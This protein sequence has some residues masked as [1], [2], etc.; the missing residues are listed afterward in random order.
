METADA[1]YPWMDDWR[2]NKHVGFLLLSDKFKPAQLEKKFPVFLEKFIEKSTSSPKRFYLLPLLD[3]HLNSKYIASNLTKSSPGEL[4]STISLAITFLLIV[5]LNFVNLSTARYSTRAK[6]VGM[7][8]VVGAGKSQ[9]IKQFLSESVLISLLAF[10]LAIL[11]FEYICPAFLSYF[12]NPFQISLWNSPFPLLLF[13]GI[14]VFTG[15]ISGIYPAFL[16][17]AFK[18]INVL[19]G[20]FTLSAKSKS[21]RKVMVI[22]QFILSIIFIVFTLGVKS[23]FDFL[24]NKDLGFTKE[25]VIVVP[26]SKDFR[27]NL[28]SIKNELIRHSDIIFVSAS[29]SLPIK[30]E[31]ECQVIPEGFTSEQTWTMNRYIIDFDF[32]ETLGMKMVKGRSFSIEHLDEKNIIINRTAMRHLQWE[33]PIGKRLIIAGDK[34]TIVGVVE[35]FHFRKLYY[36]IAPSVLYIDTN[37]LNYLYIKTSSEFNSNTV[38]FI[39]QQR[40]LFAPDIPFEYSIL[41]SEFDQAYVDIKKSASVG[42]IVSCVAIFLSCLGLLGLANF[43]LARRIIEIGIRK[44]HGA[45]VIQIFTM[46][47]KEFVILVVLSNMIAWPISYYLLSNMLQS[48][49][50]YHVHVGIEIFIFSALIS[51]AMAVLSISSQSLK[52]ASTNPVN[53]LRYE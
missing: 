30:W 2:V 14:T 32:I 4:F 16:L 50:A 9:L 1:F 13:L 5:C 8:K 43:S 12:G 24:I 28:D 49:Y 6:E 53:A 3:Y 19:K 39:R 10:P 52:V 31:S 25:K 20:Y 22:I 38:N 27:P 47:M 40:H 26:I 42:G 46:L 15:I 35:D 48:G 29:E 17:S 7:R 21:T 23:Q 41:E 37:K 45:S 36:N 34:R 11:I 33:D 51:M 44:V 18:S